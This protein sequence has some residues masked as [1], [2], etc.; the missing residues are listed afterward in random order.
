[1]NILVMNGSPKQESS[2]TLHITRAALDRLKTMRSN[3]YRL[4]NESK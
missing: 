3:R 2:D 1:M 4:R